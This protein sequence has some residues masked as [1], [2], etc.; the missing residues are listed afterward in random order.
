MFALFEHIFL[1]PMW[2]RSWLTTHFVNLVEPRSALRL[3]AAGT[4]TLFLLSSPAFSALHLLFLPLTS[5]QQRQAKTHSCT[6]GLMGANGFLF[7]WETFP[8]IK[9]CGEMFTMWELLATF[10]EKQ[11][12]VV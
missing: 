3:V 12:G 7:F 2:Y 8:R 11:P 4:Q 6:V 5:Y 9:A 10:R 1:L